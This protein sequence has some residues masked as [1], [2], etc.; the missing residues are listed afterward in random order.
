MEE[1]YHQR[2][3]A[4]ITD[5]CELLLASDAFDAWNEAGKL[6]VDDLVA[7]NNSFLYREGRTTTKSKQ[8]LGIRIG[9]GERFLLPPV[10]LETEGSINVQ[11]KQIRNSELTKYDIT[12]LRSAIS[13]EAPLLGS[14]L[15]SLAGRIGEAESASV[16]VTGVRDIRELRYLP[17]QSIAVHLENAVLSI[18]TVDDLDL[19]WAEIE[20][21]AKMNRIDVKKLSECFETAFHALQEAV[22]Y[23]VDLKDVNDHSSFLL[24]DIYKRTNE[25]VHAFSSALQINSEN[26]DDKEAYNEL[27]RVAYNFAD[28]AR[29]FLSLMIGIC[30]LKPLI[31]WLTVFEQVDLAHQFI[32]LPFS[33]VGEA[34]PS[35]ERYRSVIADA[36]NHAFH[37]L[38]AFKHPFRIDLPHDALRSPQLHLFRQYTN[39]SDPALTFEDRKLVDLFETLTRTAEHTVPLGFWE[40]NIGVMDG[41]VN[42]IEALRKALIIVAH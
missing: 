36:R 14:I 2:I 39:H 40:C 4:A 30:D 16:S 24:G 12:D 10:V 1:G 11:F 18:S 35:L 31:S 25:Q 13:R 37:D 6:R 26:P 28:G 3:E 23:P 42:L 19:T 27:L 33:L 20:E 21:F 38:F 9:N 5:Q 32:K 7:I 41:I 22:T 8:Y 34:K 15:F 29:S 17:A